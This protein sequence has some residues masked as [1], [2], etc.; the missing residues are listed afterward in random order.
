MHQPFHTRFEQ[1]EFDYQTLIDALKEYARPRD[2]ITDLIRKGVIVRIK[3]GLYVL[4]QGYAQRPYSKELLANLIY[5]P[6]YISLDWA[7]RHY[8]MIPERVEAVTSVTTGRSRRFVTPA[9][10]FIY[11]NIPLTAFRYG[12]TQMET[13]D[14]K[15]FLIAS[16]AKA[17]C[18]K[19]RD[20]RGIGMRSI[21]EMQRYLTTELRMDESALAALDPSQIEKIANG[22]QSAKLRLLKKYLDRLH[23]LNREGRP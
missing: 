21:K 17:L 11:R 2:K 9:G 3:K 8:D 23:R 15:T 20:D 12:M 10:L 19:I 18:D 1:E 22:Y 14:G 16:A 5:G 6:S 4:G 7:L 13:E